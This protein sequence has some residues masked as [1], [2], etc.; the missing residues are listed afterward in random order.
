MLHIKKQTKK[1]GDVYCVKL[2]YAHANY[3]FTM[4]RKVYFNNKKASSI[5]NWLLKCN[6]ILLLGSSVKKI[7]YP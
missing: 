5:K 7:Q 2:G 4:E 1:N 3:Y 6:T